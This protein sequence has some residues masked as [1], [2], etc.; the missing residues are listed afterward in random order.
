MSQTDHDLEFE[1]AGAHEPKD[2]R[3]ARQLF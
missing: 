2:F 1:E 3:G